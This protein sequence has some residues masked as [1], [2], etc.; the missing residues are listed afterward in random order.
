MAEARSTLTTVG[1]LEVAVAVEVEVAA[2]KK[3]LDLGDVRRGG[4]H[5]SKH[6][7][8]AAAAKLLIAPPL[9]PCPNEPLSLSMSLL[10]LVLVLLPESPP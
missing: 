7:L 8:T 1:L 6:W 5:T 10:V 3:C 9:M 4:E 2:E